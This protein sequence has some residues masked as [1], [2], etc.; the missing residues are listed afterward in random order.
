MNGVFVVHSFVRASVYVK[1]SAFYGYAPLLPVV[2]TR[3]SNRKLIRY[4]VEVD[5]VS[6]ISIKIKR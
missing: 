3:F 2:L 5:P 4:R 1:S 6:A